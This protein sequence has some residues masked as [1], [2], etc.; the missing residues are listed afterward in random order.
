MNK[1]YMNFSLTTTTVTVVA[2]ETENLETPQSTHC[3]TASC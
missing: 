2:G 3:I 1:Y